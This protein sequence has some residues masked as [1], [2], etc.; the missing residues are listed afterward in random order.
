MV[1]DVPS[2]TITSHPSNEICSPCCDC[3]CC[4]TYRCTASAAAVAANIPL[5]PPPI[6]PIRRR[7]WP[8]RLDGIDDSNGEED[9]AVVETDSAEAEEVD[10]DNGRRLEMN[11]M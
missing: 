8:S 1:F 10:V 2:N 11:L 6:I 5:A 7:R 3:C 4:D 9:E